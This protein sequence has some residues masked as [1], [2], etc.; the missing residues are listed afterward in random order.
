[1]LGLSHHLRELW[2]DAGRV[3]L[4]TLGV[5]WGTMAVTVLIVFGGS[6]SHTV[7]RA[8]QGLG[9]GVVV[10]RSGATSVPY[11]GL[12]SARPIELTGRD[13]EALRAGVPE[14]E[15][16]SR[17]YS[18]GGV[19]L[20]SDGR[21]HHVYVS[22]VE[23][24]YG[25]IRSCLPQSGGRFINE[26]DILHRRR[27]A[28]LGNVLKAQVFGARDA[29]GRTVLLAGR[30]F[31]VIGVLEP[32]EQWSSYQGEDNERLYMPATT[33]EAM[34]GPQ[35]VS[36]IVYRASQEV[37]S[38]D[39]VWSV[40]RVLGRRHRFN[41]K[42]LFALSVWDTVAGME[43]AEST[44]R[45][46]LLCMGI[47]GVVTLVVAGV[48][49][50]N[51]MYVLVKSRT[52]EIAIKVAVGARPGDITTYHL[53]EGFLIVVVGGGLGLGFSWLLT[54]VLGMIPLKEEA[55]LYFGHPT[56]SV[57]AVALVGIVLGLIGLLAG[58]FP[59][60]RAAMTDPAEALRYE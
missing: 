3:A 1:M 60:R 29:V 43:I 55:L 49:V 5:M 24:D 39:V 28:F 56:M 47:I 16:I 30:P 23:P 10:L 14:I 57:G 45:G 21:K 37:D 35:Y 27:V 13:A 41:P 59:A 42:D 40:R 22:A 20:L 52:R 46:V 9:Q 25:E 44:H 36:A 31:L 15:K 32:K 50:G 48:G 8:Q 19:E 12:P 17:E 34:W 11:D 58:F 53:I 2:Q 51:V 7:L 6:S 38:S 54:V 4:T 18:R 33:F 26:Q